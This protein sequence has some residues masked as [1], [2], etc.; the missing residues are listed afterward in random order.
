MEV[1]NAQPLPNDGYSAEYEYKLAGM[2]VQ[3]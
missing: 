3:P 1:D 2:R